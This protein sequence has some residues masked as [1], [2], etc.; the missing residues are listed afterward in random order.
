MRTNEL[1]LSHVRLLN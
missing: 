1:R